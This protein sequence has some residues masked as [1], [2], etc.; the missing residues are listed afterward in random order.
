MAMPSLDR[1]IPTARGYEDSV[2]VEFD[3]RVLEGRHGRPVHCQ[4]LRGIP[5]GSFLRVY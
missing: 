2:V 1:Q 4:F 3:R 5:P